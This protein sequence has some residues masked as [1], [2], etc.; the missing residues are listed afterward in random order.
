MHKLSGE[1]EGE[2]A[3]DVDELDVGVPAGSAQDGKGLVGGKFLSAPESLAQL[4]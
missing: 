4:L 3:G 1:G 2:G